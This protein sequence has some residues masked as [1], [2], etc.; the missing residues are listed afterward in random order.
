[1]SQQMGF[2]AEKEALHYLLSQGLTWIESNYHCRMGEI[3]LI[4]WHGETLV[5]VEVKARASRVYGGAVA[6]VTY[7]KQQ[8]LI[9]TASLYLLHK[10]SY[11]KHPVRFDVIGMEGVPARVHW[12]QNAFGL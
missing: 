3:D 9:K 10:K 5:F 8:K 1:M 2:L 11:D 4:M 6:S 7:A 12:I